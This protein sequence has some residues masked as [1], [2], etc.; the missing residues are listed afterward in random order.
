MRKILSFFLLYIGPCP[1]QRRIVMI[2][3]DS[4]QNWIKASMWCSTEEIINRFE[5]I[6]SKFVK[7]HFIPTFQ[8]AEAG[9]VCGSTLMYS[10]YR[11]VM[12]LI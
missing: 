12:L 8:L 2:N 1:L 11:T 5:D 10:I 9:N 4:I 6:E 3:E 7:F